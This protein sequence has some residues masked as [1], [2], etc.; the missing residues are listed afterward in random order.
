MSGDL[1]NRQLGASAMILALLVVAMVVA[2]IVVA[3]AL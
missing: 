1:N 3:L 2:A